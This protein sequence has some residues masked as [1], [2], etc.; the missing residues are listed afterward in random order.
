MC[1]NNKNYLST[2]DSILDHAPSSPNSFVQL[3]YFTTLSPETDAC[4]CLKTVRK[5][6]I[7]ISG[8]INLSGS[9]SV[10]FIRCAPQ[11]VQSYF[12]LGGSDDSAWGQYGQLGCFLHGTR[13]LP[14]GM[15]CSACRQ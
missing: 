12:L 2:I 13:Y 6:S 8:D 15:N 1:L 9:M 7:L 14:T 5:S 11:S 10:I 4:E 3:V